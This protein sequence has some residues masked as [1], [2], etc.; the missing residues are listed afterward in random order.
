MNQFVEPKAMCLTS[1]PDDAYLKLPAI[2]NNLNISKS[3]WYKGIRENSYPRPVKIGTRS[4]WIAGE[5]KAVKAELEN[6]RKSR[7]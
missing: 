4:R 7:A 3:E 1:I 5:I 6:E 2:L